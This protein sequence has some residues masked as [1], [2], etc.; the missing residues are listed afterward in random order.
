M[1]LEPILLPPG[2][3][4]ARAIRPCEECGRLCE[5]RLSQVREGAM[6]LCSRVC[7]SKA[8]YRIRTTRGDYYQPIKPRRGC[9]IICETCGKAF[10][11]SQ[12]Q[13]I[14]GRR[15]CSNKCHNKSQESKVAVRCEVCGAVKTFSKSTAKNRRCCSLKCYEQFR[16]K[17]GLGR[18]HNGKEARLNSF[19]Y[20]MIWEPTHSKR[21]WAFEHRVLVEK[22]LGRRLRSDEHVHHIDSDKTNNA[23]PN[24]QVVD[25]RTHGRITGKINTARRKSTE[26]RLSEYER[27]YGPL[28]SQN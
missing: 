14:N 27:L 22:H 13:K 21:G 15:F 6:W 19:G 18:H 12:T 17:N 23:L 3:G 4:A 24:L 5:K 28:P 7:T 11:V 8:S 16:Y 10:Y 25:G 20:V 2:K 1:N 26:Q 9:D